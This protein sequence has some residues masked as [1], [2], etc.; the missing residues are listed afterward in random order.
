M[1]RS[2][3]VDGQSLST[4]SYGDGSLS[5][6]LSVSAASVAQLVV[7]VSLLYF[8]LVEQLTIRTGDQ[9]TLKVR[10]SKQRWGEAK[11]RQ[12]Q[13][14]IALS[15][16]QLEPWLV[17]LLRFSRDGRAE[18]RHLDI[19]LGEE[20]KVTFV[21]EADEFRPHLDAAEARKLLGLDD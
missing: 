2:I 6:R 11:R 8:G 4:S 13:W 12:D 9:I 3:V 20:G 7:E 15:P 19:E 16:L 5:V 1:K 18:V 14:T 10:T 21:V 17:Y